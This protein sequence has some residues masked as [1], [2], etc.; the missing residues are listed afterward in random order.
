MAYSSAL[1]EIGCADGV[2]LS[3]ARERGWQVKGVEICEYAA[4]YA[5]EQRHLDVLTGTLEQAGFCQESFGCVY[6]GDVLEHLPSPKQT[7]AEIWRV[8][9]HQ[10]ILVLEVPL[11]YNS[12]YAHIS[13]FYLCIRRQI[14]GE[15]HMMMGPPR[16]LYE[17]TPR[18][19]QRLLVMSGFEIK[20]VIY[21][22]PS[23]TL[24]RIM[25]ILPQ[26]IEGINSNRVL[27]YARKP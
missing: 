11:F 14:T 13:H 7:L 24:Q 1:L 12:L 8:M 26:V 27:V 6:M 18:T 17:F 15:A 4:R 23:R 20:R 25:S 9:S 3:K 2:F 22:T 21:R 16:H 19:L 10:G 5:R